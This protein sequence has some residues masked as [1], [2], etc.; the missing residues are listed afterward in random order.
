MSLEKLKQFFCKH[1]YKQEIND[2]KER[3]R[4]VDKLKDGESISFIRLHKCKK[5]N[6]QQMIGS[7]IHC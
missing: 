7:G 1:D 4:L 6:K 5:C 2:Q 3:N